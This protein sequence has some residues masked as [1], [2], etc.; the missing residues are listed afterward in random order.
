MA[1]A[2]GLAWSTYWGN[3]W[4]V[5]DGSTPPEPPTPPP[6]ATEQPRGTAPWLAPPV[7][8]RERTRRARIAFGV[9]KDVAKAQAQYLHLDDAQRVAHLEA[10]LRLR[11]L[12]I[13]TEY[14]ARLNA[15][16]ELLILEETRRLMA[17]VMRRRQEDDDAALAIILAAALD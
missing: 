9:I 6:A 15:E 13:E 2:W 17:E 4:G 12:E 3:S 5:I 10:E 1:S 16:R 8:H 14:L 11:G 7:D